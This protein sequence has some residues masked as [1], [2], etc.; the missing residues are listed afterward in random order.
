MAI[1]CRVLHSAMLTYNALSDPHS[2]CFQWFPGLG[3]PRGKHPWLTNK[4]CFSQTGLEITV[5]INGNLVD[6]KTFQPSQ[7]FCTILKTCFLLDILLL[8]LTVSLIWLYIIKNSSESVQ[9]Q[10]NN[11]IQKNQK[12]HLCFQETNHTHWIM[13]TFKHGLRT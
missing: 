13:T 6:I 8:K 4:N 3:G 2:H 9:N 11:V 1:C 12:R 5:F 7:N 10:S